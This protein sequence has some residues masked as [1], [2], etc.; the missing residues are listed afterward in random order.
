MAKKLNSS[1]KKFKC[2]YCEQTSNKKSNLKIHVQRK[3]KKQMA[4]DRY[5]SQYYQYNN[6]DQNTE[7]T[8]ID[9]KNS[10]QQTS[11]PEFNYNAYNALNQYYYFKI[12][13]EEEE[14]EERKRKDDRRYWNMI[15][16]MYRM[17]YIINNK[18]K[19]NTQARCFPLYITRNSIHQ[20]TL[21]NQ[22]STINS[23]LQISKPVSK[24]PYAI[25]FYKCKE[26]LNE[27]LF[28]IYD[29]TE[30]ASI[31]NSNYKGFCQL[32]HKMYPLANLGKLLK[33]CL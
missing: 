7:T 18:N 10:Y 12:E 19:Y 22:Y 15:Y 4:Y 33:N 1:N 9:I 13:K 17:Q 29:F 31:K 11:L 24:I 27:M 23:N 21:P 20:T 2:T 5:N 16:S 25:K 32:F 3:H 30:I 28:P 26:C 14:R 6:T 8:S